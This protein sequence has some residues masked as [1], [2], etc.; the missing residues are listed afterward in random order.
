MGCCELFPEYCGNI[1][2]G[3]AFEIIRDVI[4]ETGGLGGGGGCSFDGTTDCGMY[5]QLC[6]E[7]KKASSMKQL[8][9][10]YCKASSASVT[11]RPRR[12]SVM[13]F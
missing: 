3:V 13:H 9:F 5:T 12:A 7:A 1:G 10:N 8:S 6:D 2:G 11:G 4:S